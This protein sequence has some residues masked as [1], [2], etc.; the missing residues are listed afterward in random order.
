VV[1]LQVLSV[2]LVVQAMRTAGATLADLGLRVPTRQAA[3]TVTLLI[4]VGV[5]LIIYR[6]FGPPAAPPTDAFS[7]PVTLDERLVW[8]LVSLSAAFS[9]ELLYRGFAITALQGRGISLPVAVVIALVPWILN[10]GL[11]GLDR[12][13]FYVVSGLVFTAIYLWRRTLYPGMVV[14]ALV[15]LAVLAG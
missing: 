8:L 10:H 12:V 4:A 6:E 9:E 13:M 3:L 14:H 7:R 15:N 1:V 5:A 2:V 11:T